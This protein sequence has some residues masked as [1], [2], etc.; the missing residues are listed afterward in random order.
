MTKNPATHSIGDYMGP[1]ANLDTP[2]EEKSFS[3]QELNLDFLV[4][5]LVA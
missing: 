1:T 4:H 3:L 2:D 5:K